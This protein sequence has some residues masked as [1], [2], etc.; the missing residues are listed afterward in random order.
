MSVVRRMDHFTIVTDKLDK[1]KFS[2]V[3]QSVDFE[4]VP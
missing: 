2:T 3:T 1:S 4:I